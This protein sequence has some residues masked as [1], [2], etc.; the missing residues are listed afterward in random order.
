MNKDRVINIPR[1]R[2]ARLYVCLTNR[3]LGSIICT[4]SDITHIELWHTRVGFIYTLADILSKLSWFLTEEA[5]SHGGL[6]KR[7]L[8]QFIIS[9]IKWRLKHLYQHFGS[10]LGSLCGFL[11]G[12]P[13]DSQLTSQLNSQLASFSWPSSWALSWMTRKNIIERCIVSNKGCYLLL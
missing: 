9:I 8:G 13:L 2:A 11:L 10:Q 1:V 3:Y 5:Y 12:S 6:Q 7:E 4:Q